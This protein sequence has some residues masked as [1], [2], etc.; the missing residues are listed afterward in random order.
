[1]S[2]ITLRIEY[3]LDQCLHGE[4]EISKSYM[5]HFR[6]HENM[7][8]CRHS[9]KIIDNLTARCQRSG[10]VNLKNAFSLMSSQ[11]F[12]SSAPAVNQIQLKGI[13]VFSRTVVPSGL[14]DLSV[15]FWLPI[16][17]LWQDASS[18]VNLSRNKQRIDRKRTSGRGVHINRL[19]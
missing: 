17:C 4:N 19:K 12:V 6:Q 14:I 13:L 16:V 11:M 1:M 2:L 15:C 3:H 10:R 18:C 5:T 7:D 9:R 8:L